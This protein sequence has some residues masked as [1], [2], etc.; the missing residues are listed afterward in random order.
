MTSRF[1]QP[2]FSDQASARLVVVTGAAGFIGRRVVARLAQAGAK[3]IAMDRVPMPANLPPGVDYRCVELGQNFPEIT[4]E[5]LLI[6]LAW[7]MDRADTKAQATS[8]AD[9]A[10]L[11][12][13]KG[14]QGVVGLGSAEEYGELEGCLSE[15]MAPGMKLSAYG[16]AKHE[17]CR[18]LENWAC[19][20]SQCAI[21]L[22]PFVVYGPGQGGNMAIPYALSCAQKRQKADFSEG[23]QSRDFVHVDDVADGI[24]QAALRLQGIGDSFVV[25][26]LG[27][28]KP[29][30]VRDVLERIVRKRNA[31]ELFNFGARPMRTGEP[32]EQYADVSAAARRLGWRALISWE[33]GIDEL[34]VNKGM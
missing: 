29:I 13:T 33:Q 6:H 30:K 25:C 10:R 24:A 26:N 18:I 32:M 4:N 27:C 22:R 11:L 16:K 28:G 31:A 5:F 2:D 14:L 23:L 15:D 17:A 3:V 21:W 34:C 8:V 7:N 9:F 12:E 19:R 1:S 20:L